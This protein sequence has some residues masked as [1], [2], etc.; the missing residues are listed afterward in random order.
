MDKLSKHITNNDKDIN[1]SVQSQPSPCV[2]P[3]TTLRTQTL[4]SLRQ[5]EHRTISANKALHILLL[6]FGIF[7]ALCAASSIYSI[8]EGQIHRQQLW[9]TEQGLTITKEVVAYQNVDRK[10]VADGAASAWESIAI[11]SEISGLKI[12]AVLVKEGEHVVHGQPLA[13][14]NDSVLR[15]ELQ[16]AQAVLLASKANLQKSVQPNRSEDIVSLKAAEAQATDLIAQAEANAKSIRTRCLNAENNADRFTV[17]SKEGAVSDMEAQN[18]QTEAIAMRA[19]LNR[20]EE[21]VR[22]ANQAFKQAQAHFKLA[23]N[24][25]RREDVS[26]SQ[27]SVMEAQAKIS[28]LNALLSQTVIKAPENGLIVKSEARHGELAITGQPIFHLVRD[29]RLELKVKV[30][31]NQLL[32]IHPGQTAVIKSRKDS[33]DVLYGKVRELTPSVDENT[34]LGTVRIDIPKNDRVIPG[35]FFHV[36]LLVSNEQAIAVP[37][38][39]IM[40][41]DGQAYVFAISGDH[42]K[43]VVVKVGESFGDKLEIKNGLSAGQ[44]IAVSGASFLKDGDRVTVVSQ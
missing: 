15:A 21:Q 11:S 23:I 26:I 2:K 34:R 41:T 42:V 40:D 12:N 13:N 20:A 7:L 19:E 36:E 32:M 18:T 5:L 30:P 37:K 8:I 10:V 39:A 22:A 24:G 28:K 38:E 27:A 29:D 6:V 43:R 31:E 9:G 16:E 44:T 35:M 14:L 1:S 33:A 3:E 17:L 4:S 25:G